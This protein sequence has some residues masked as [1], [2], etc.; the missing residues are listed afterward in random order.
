MED[1][2]NFFPILAI[3][4][5]FFGENDGAFV[6]FE[7]TEKDFDFVTDL[8]VIDVIEFAEGDDAF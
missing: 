4:G 7:A 5:L 8:E 2:D 1:G 3:G 6:V